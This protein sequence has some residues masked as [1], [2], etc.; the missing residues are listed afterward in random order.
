MTD[1]IDTEEPEYDDPEPRLPRG[2]LE[3]D[4]DRVCRAYD[5]NQITLPEGKYMTPYQ[6]GSELI[7]ET[8]GGRKRPSTGAISNILKKWE[9][10]GYCELRTNPNAFVSLSMPARL[11]PSWQIYLENFGFEASDNGD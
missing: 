11:M 9:Q 3:S 6:I 7:A 8:D 1:D 10:A 5:S 4:V 2:Y